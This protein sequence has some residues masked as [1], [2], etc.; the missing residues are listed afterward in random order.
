M[1][2]TS[3]KTFAD[4]FGKSLTNFK[5]SMSKAFY[6][7]M[8]SMENLENSNTIDVASI[9]TT[10]NNNNQRLDRRS[11]DSNLLTDYLKTL[12]NEICVLKGI[13]DKKETIILNLTKTS[14]EE[15]I[16]YEKENLELKQQIEQLQFENYQLKTVHQPDN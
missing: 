3:K 16:R 4:K 7:H 13:I 1:R 15:R 8:S 6:P 9:Q 5:V 11:L 2:K 14:D 12:Q 10:N